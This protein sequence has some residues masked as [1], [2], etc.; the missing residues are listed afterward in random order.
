MFLRFVVVVEHDIFTNITNLIGWLNISIFW[1]LTYANL[2][3][4]FKQE[5]RSGPC[6]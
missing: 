4:I 5:K 2:I 1:M 3:Y 6:C